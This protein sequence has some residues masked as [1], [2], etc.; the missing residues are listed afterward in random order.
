MERLWPKIDRIFEKAEGEGRDRLLEPE[1]YALLAAAGIRPPR[2]VFLPAG[3]PVP[4][5]IMAAFPGE[6][7]VLKVVSPLVQHKTEAGGVAFVPKKASVVKSK[8]REMAASAGGGLR[9]YL[10]VEKVAFE[11]FGFGTELLVGLRHSRE[12]GPVVSVGAGGTEVEFLG[13]RMAEGQSAAVLSAHLT[14]EPEILDRLSGLAVTAKLTAPFRGRPAPLRP[15]EL[16]RV[17]SLFLKLGAHYSAFRPATRFV[18]E[19][20]EVNPFVVR[21]GRLV[22]LDGLARFSRRKVPLARRPPENIRALLRPGAIAVIGVS[23][24]MNLGRIVLRNILKMGF[25]KERLTVVKPGF[26]EIDGCRCVPTVSA[27][28]EP[29]DLFVLTLSADQCLPVMEELAAAGLARSVIVIAG[30]MGEKEGTES[31]EERIVDLLAA[32]RAAGRPTPVVNGGNCLGI[33]SKPGR[34][35]T[36]FI[37][38]SKLRFPKSESSELAVVSQSGAFMICRVSAL[39]RHEPL[40]AVSVGNQLDL[41][42]SDYLD[43]LKDD[44][45]A[46]VFAVYVEGFKPGDGL[47]AAEAAR[48]ILATEGRAVIVY[49]SG[50]TPEGRAATAGHTASVAGDYA[51]AKAVLGSAGA[52]LAES[53]AEFENCV[54]GFLALSGKKAGGRRVALL[55]N[56]GFE[57]VIM[58]D[59][60]GRGA[61]LELAA[62][63]PATRA[64]L[65]AALAPLGIEK[66]QDIKNPL[67]LTPVADDTA[68]AACAEAV[69]AD[70]GVDAAVFSPVPMTPAMQ[71]LPPSELSQE[72]LAAEG[73]VSSRLIA[74]YRASAKPFIVNIDAGP[75]YDPLADHLE[76]AGLPVFRRSDEAVAFLGRFVAASRRRQFFSFSKNGK[77]EV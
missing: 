10:L 4:A 18:L 48:R 20:A 11:E 58:S 63:S 47:L 49:K 64:R 76:D 31:L 46:R 71:T 45:Q 42:V 50:R 19:E 55:S 74:L 8:M 67:D 3:R 75:D 39:G 25:P 65:A 17:V 2:H 35:D 15:E 68:F 23:E 13:E 52:V 44:P 24:K 40:F 9:G 30:G 12:F 53:I 56:A 51:V 1:V 29:V 37:P 21:S 26:D 72:N 69:L 77:L 6:E 16:R 66:L 60:L 34:Y 61:F 70:A 38:D 41:R 7:V 62:F 54:R 43:Y 36:T 27:L 5:G 57:S 33:Y 73:S 14:G 28:P 32:G 59:G 22:P